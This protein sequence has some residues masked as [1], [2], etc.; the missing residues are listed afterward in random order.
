MD[1]VFQLGLC[2]EIQK[3]RLF[4]LKGARKARQLHEMSFLDCH[5]RDNRVYAYAF[6]VAGAPT[7]AGDPCGNKADPRVSAAC[8]W[9]VL[10]V[11][12]S[13]RFICFGNY[14]SKF[15][16]WRKNLLPP[17][18]LL[19]PFP[20]YCISPP[21]WILC[22]GFPRCRLPCSSG[23]SFP[24]SLPRARGRLE[25]PHKV[26][27]DLLLCNKKITVEADNLFTWYLWCTLHTASG[28]IVSCCL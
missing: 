1:L 6:A 25:N 21:I 13:L 28:N 17:S 2:C 19:L 15:P 27:K 11:R 14:P 23:S 10:S 7:H 26:L 16:F 9:P 20:I 24:P 22:L 8:E 5:I 4:P 18:N 12:T 3:V